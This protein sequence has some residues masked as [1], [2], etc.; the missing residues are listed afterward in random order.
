MPKCSSPLKRNAFEYVI[1]RQKNDWSLSS[2]PVSLASPQKSNAVENKLIRPFDSICY[3]T[4][5]CTNST[6]TSSSQC[7][8]RKACSILICLV[9]LIKHKILTITPPAGPWG[10]IPLCTSQTYANHVP[11]FES[12]KY[13]ALMS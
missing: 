6:F 2:P 12:I 9:P 10:L 7:L 11:N 13:L 3:M 1:W 5:A 4:I 8:K